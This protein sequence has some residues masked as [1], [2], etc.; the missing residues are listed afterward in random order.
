MSHR[1]PGCV[2]ASRL[3]MAAYFARYKTFTLPANQQGKG[4]AIN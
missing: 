1:L 3:M 4:F 2:A